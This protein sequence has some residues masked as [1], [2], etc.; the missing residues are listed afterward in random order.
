M[1]TIGTSLS[2]LW[3]ASVLPMQGSP[4]TSARRSRT[5]FSKRSIGCEHTEGPIPCPDDVGFKAWSYEKRK[6]SKRQRSPHAAACSFCMGEQGATH[7]A[8]VA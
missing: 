8:S 2:K 7:S 6:G 3:R 4:D 1:S 5:G